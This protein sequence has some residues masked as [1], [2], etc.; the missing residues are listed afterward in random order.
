MRDVIIIG[1]GPAGYTAGIY[2]ARARLF[3]LVLEGDLAGGLLMQ[4]TTVEN[5]PGF[6]DGVDG[7]ELMVGMRKQAERFGAKMVAEKATAVD[8]SA[9]PF[10]VTFGGET[11]EARAVIV[12]TGSTPRRLGV[13]SEEALY[14]HGVSSCAI[15]DAFFYRGKRVAVVGGGDA[16]LEEADLLSR[17]AD[18]V[19][20]LVRRDVFRAS[21][22]MQER[23]L[24]N[25]KIEIRWNTLVDDV[26]GADVGRVTGARL[27]DAKTGELSEIAVDGFFPIVGHDPNSE[28]FRGQLELDE[29]GYVR[30]VGETTATSVPGVFVAGDIADH[31]Y[32]QAI[33]AAGAG[34]Q[35]GLDALHYL[36]ENP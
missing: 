34:C 22:A 21:K 28:I 7:P 9:R 25:E 4:T 17:F 13:P 18:K 19:I 3:P 1:G 27:K 24:N 30:R 31:R 32:R 26:L 10:K 15:C 36:E 29:A 16:A 12:A 11:E 33:T 6:P 2:C 35:A 8:F 14:G 23:V 20:M 5:F